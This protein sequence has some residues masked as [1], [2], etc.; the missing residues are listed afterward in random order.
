MRPKTRKI[1]TSI[2]P[3]SRHCEVLTQDGRNQP[4]TT[5]TQPPTTATN[6]QIR[7]HLYHSNNHH[8]S[9]MQ[10]PSLSTHTP[11][12]P[13]HK[14]IQS[15]QSS[16]FYLLKPSPST[17]YCRQP[18]KPATSIW[19]C[20]QVTNCPNKIDRV[21]EE[22]SRVSTDW[23]EIERVTRSRVLYFNNDLRDRINRSPV[24]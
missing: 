1:T 7:H 8:W 18:A 24:A 9:L 23:K 11:T 20:L 5:K 17:I 21:S 12:H 3:F 2:L 6:S 15:L 16:R 13:R 19:K 14:V 22:G 10:A 4:A